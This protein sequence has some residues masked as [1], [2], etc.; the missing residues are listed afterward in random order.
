LD[1]IRSIDLSRKKKNMGFQK[2]TPKEVVT[3]YQITPVI[4]AAVD[5]EAKLPHP[6]NASTRKSPRLK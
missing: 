1:L 2:P 6:G 3:P 4:A 5:P